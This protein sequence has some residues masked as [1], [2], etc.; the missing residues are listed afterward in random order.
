MFPPIPPVV[1]ECDCSVKPMS[2][3]TQAQAV[4]LNGVQ[5]CRTRAEAEQFLDDWAEV[6]QKIK[7]DILP[8]MYFPE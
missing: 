2:N 3:K 7:T 1:P 5:K 4:M 8:D 6:I